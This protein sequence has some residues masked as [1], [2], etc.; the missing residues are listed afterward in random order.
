VTNNVMIKDG[1]LTLSRITYFSDLQRG[2]QFPLGVMAEIMIVG[3]VHGLGLISRT[4]LEETELA[5]VGR[6]MTDALKSP[7]E[8]LK[9][10]FDWAWNNAPAGGALA[11]L[12]NKNSESLFFA[13]PT[14]ALIRR[15]FRSEAEI[16]D[17]ARRQLRE[18]RDSEFDLMLAELLHPSP[19]SEEMAKLAA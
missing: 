5:S 16:A 15:A 8:L 10:E 11:A 1:W 9:S 4:G 12:C 6:L 13:S 14:K 18:Q 17:F 2:V 7:F 19:Y 3:S